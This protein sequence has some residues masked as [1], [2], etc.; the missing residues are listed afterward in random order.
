[1]RWLTRVS[2]DGSIANFGIYCREVVE[3]LNKMPERERAFPLMVA[4]TGYRSS[5]PP[6]EHAERLD[7]ETTYTFR[8][9]IK[10][11]LTIVLGHSEAR[12]ESW[13]AWESGLRSSRLSSYS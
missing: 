4:W 11:A 10:L 1:M 13:L 6:V 7:G 8:K 12:Y 5:K 3:T 9:L 2:Q